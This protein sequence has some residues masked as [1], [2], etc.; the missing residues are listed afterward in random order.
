MGL[1]EVARRFLIWPKA[2]NLS[3]CRAAGVQQRHAIQVG[4][5]HTG[6]A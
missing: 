2:M 1:V 6:G 3:Y 5:L 4:R